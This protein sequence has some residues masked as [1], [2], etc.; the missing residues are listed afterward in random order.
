MAL[1]TI[2][3]ILLFSFLFDEFTPA[4]ILFPALLGIII[5]L[6]GI[7]RVVP[8]LLLLLIGVGVVAWAVTVILDSMSE[9][10]HWDEPDS[11]NPRHSD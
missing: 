3:I 6:D 8:H 1:I 11:K 9:D 2:G 4:C 7:G 10:N 5:A